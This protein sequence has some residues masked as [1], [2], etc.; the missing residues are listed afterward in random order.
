MDIRHVTDDIAKLTLAGIRTGDRVLV[1][2]ERRL[3]TYT[4]PQLQPGPG[5][6]PRLWIGDREG[7]DLGGWYQ[8]AGTIADRRRFLHANDSQ[9]RWSTSAKRWEVVNG[10]SVVVWYA[11]EDIANPW[12]VSQWISVTPGKAMIVVAREDRVT[13]PEDWVTALGGGGGGAWYEPWENLGMI[14]RVDSSKTGAVK[15]NSTNVTGFGGVG[16]LAIPVLNTFNQVQA[17]PASFPPDAP[18]PYNI[19]VEGDLGPLTVRP[20]GITGEAIITTAALLRVGVPLDTETKV[21]G[22]IVGAPTILHLNGQEITSIRAKNCR[23]GGNSYLASPSHPYSLP[24]LD[25]RNNLLT[26]N[27]LNQLFEDLGQAV[28]NT[29]NYMLPSILVTG[30][31][32][33]ATCDPTIATAKGYILETGV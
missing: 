25:L 8:P 4:G 24:Y 15:T 5:T 1:G 2:E 32:G 22:P 21:T 3:E 13:D 17:F 27:A 30:N 29:T 12:D 7:D 9:V 26:A 14:I 19:R 10:A 33:A 6:V 16:A 11:A 28:T 18:M 31:P 23:G 20:A